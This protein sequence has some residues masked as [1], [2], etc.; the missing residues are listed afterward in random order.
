MSV[1]ALLVLCFP[2]A[3]DL[4]SILSHIFMSTILCCV[5]VSVLYYVLVLSTYQCYISALRNIMTEN[6][7]V[8]AKSC[9]S[10]QVGELIT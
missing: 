1:L 2:H 10:S 8:A 5:I 6:A 9:V 7:P 3:V 4:R